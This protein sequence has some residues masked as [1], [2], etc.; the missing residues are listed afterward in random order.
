MLHELRERIV[1]EIALDE[2][3]KKN[4]PIQSSTTLTM[5]RKASNNTFEQLGF[6]E[7]MTYGHR[8]SLRKECSRF[9]RFAY[10]VDFLSMEALS[11]IYI[12]SVEGILERLDEL[13]ATA[14]MEQIAK[15]EIDETVKQHAPPNRGKEPLFHIA[16][17]LSDDREIPEH[18]VKEVEAEEFK[19]PPHGQSAK[20]DFDLLCHI[21]FEKDEEEDGKDKG[22]DD[23]GSGAEGDAPA[24]EDEVKRVKLHVPN[25]Q[26]YWLRVSPSREEFEGQIMDCFTKGLEAI[27]SFE[28]WA[29]HSELSIY[30][31]ILEEWDDIVGDVWE[32]PDNLFLNPSNWVNEHPAHTEQQERL[33]GI[34]DEAFQKSEFFQQR[35]QPLLEIHWRNKKVDLNVLVH[36]KLRNPTDV[37]SNSIQLLNYHHAFFQAKLPVTTDLGLLQLDSKKCRETLLPTPKACISKIEQIIPAVLRERTDAA[38]KWLQEATRNLQK[39]VVNVEDFVEQNNHLVYVNDNFQRVRDNVDLYGQYNNILAEYQLKQKKEDKDNFTE[40]V[41]LITQLSTIVTNVESAQDSNMDTFKRTLEELIPQLNVEIDALHGESIDDVF[42]SGDAKMFDMLKKL[43]ELEVRFKE[44]EDRSA[45][46]NHWQEVLQTQPSMFDNL[47]QLREDLSL[48]SLMWRSLKEWEELT[49][50]WVNQKFAE[51]SAD[52]IGALADQ[53][54]KKCA[55]IEKN[56]PENPIGMKLKEL[57]DTFK[58]AMPIVKALRN[59]HLGERHWKDIQNLVQAE[60]NVNDDDFTLNSL[61]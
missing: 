45:K 25:I 20:E 12:G 52:D 53:F 7:G 16:V 31:D 10:L 48:R 14:T 46:Y 50:K 60:F 30:A 8:S 1:S 28:C 17:E 42:L 55:R 22:D 34:L 39:P 47:D 51:I 37:L 61:I 49:D 18:E 15:I 4:N 41:Q 35:F 2:E 5:K 57:V 32:E 6:P 40:A 38:K 21:D 19:L 23:E 54:S 36:E 11:S 43:D 29:K 9:L 33:G 56:L 3:R 26:S 13:N 59:E 58:G 27:Q 24:A 44:L